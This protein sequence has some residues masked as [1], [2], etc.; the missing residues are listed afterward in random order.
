MKNIRSRFKAFISRASDNEDLQTERIREAMLSALDKNC[1][2]PHEA[3]ARS[4]S[5][6]TDL[7]TLWYLRSDLFHAISSCCDQLKAV[8]VMSEITLLFKGHLALANS[9]RI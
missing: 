5:Y 7:E 9:T 8:S 2:K 6:A 4:I 3:I 1:F